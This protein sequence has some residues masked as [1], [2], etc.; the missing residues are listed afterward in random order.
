MKR[1]NFTK[2]VAS[3]NDFIVIDKPVTNPHLLARRACE[4]K[5]GIGA[6]GL[7]LIQKIRNKDFRMRIFNPDGSEAEMCGNGARCLA[8]YAS[9][10]FKTKNLRLFTKAGIIEAQTN[11]D[12][13]KIKMSHPKDRQLDIAVQLHERSLKVNYID[14]GVPHAVVFVEGLHNIDVNNIGRQIRYHKRFQPRGTNVNFVEVYD[15]NYIG[16]RTYERGVEGE[17]LACGT[18]VVASSLIAFLKIFEGKTKPKNFLMKAKTLSTEVL[19]VYFNYKEDKFLDV[20][21]EGKVNN[22]CKGEYNV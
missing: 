13:A 11:K 3:G 19:N 9:S 4:R 21:L 10:K 14:S 7:L 1:I 6:D 20:W 12:V 16:V 17:T 5:T 18:G 8:I 22:I 2:M 15:R